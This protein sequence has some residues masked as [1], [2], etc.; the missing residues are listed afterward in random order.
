MKT[1]IWLNNEKYADDDDDGSGKDT[2]GWW[3]PVPGLHQIFLAAL[4]SSR[5]IVV[6]PSVGL[7]VGPSV[8]PSVRL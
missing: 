8:R 7:S 6:R 5:S 2:V 4:S 1:T 3:G